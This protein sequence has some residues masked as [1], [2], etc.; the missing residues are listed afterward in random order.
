[1]K[2][3]KH[4]ASLPRM[5]SPHT[6][7]PEMT[8]RLGDLVLRQDLPGT[9]GIYNYSNS[10]ERKEKGDTRQDAGTS[11]CMCV[12]VA[13]QALPCAPPVSEP[14]TRGDGGLSK[15][16]SF[17]VESSRPDGRAQAEGSLALRPVGFSQAC[18][19]G[20]DRTGNLKRVVWKD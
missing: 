7:V 4:S 8:G 5:S 15:P 14:V 20:T 19:P 12:S 16:Q 17:V 11:A 18:D 9:C 1:M 10:I 2:A 3:T 13:S 6:R